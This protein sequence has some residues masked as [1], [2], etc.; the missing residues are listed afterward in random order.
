MRNVTEGLSVP[1]QNEVVVNKHRVGPRNTRPTG[2]TDFSAG[3]FAMKTFRTSVAAAAAIM[4]MTLTGPAH[5]ADPVSKIGEPIQTVAAATPTLE[6][7]HR[8]K[9][10]TETKGPDVQESN[11]WAMLAAGLCIGMLIISRRRRT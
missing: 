3:N 1:D 11:G 7:A 4:A 9:R 8:V 10:S 5:A 6:V 2:T